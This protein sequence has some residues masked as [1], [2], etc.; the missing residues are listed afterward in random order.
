MQF[1]GGLSV[2]Q[3]EALADVLGKPIRPPASFQSVPRDA[4]WWATGDEP[5]LLE[6]VK[7]LFPPAGAAPKVSDWRLTR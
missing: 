6:L 1:N 5:D 7:G 4:S 3:A 2:E